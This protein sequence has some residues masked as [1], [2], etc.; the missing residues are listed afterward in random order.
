MEEA[1]STI[2]MGF[3]RINNDV[4]LVWILRTVELNLSKGAASRLR[5]LVVGIHAIFKPKGT[6]LRLSDLL[7]V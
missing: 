3:K 2:V 6:I 7:I 4:T 1:P 5:D